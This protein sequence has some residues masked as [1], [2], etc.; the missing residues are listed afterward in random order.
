MAFLTWGELY[1]L[2][3]DPALEAW[4]QGVEAVAIHLRGLPE[5]RLVDLDAHIA[6]VAH[7]DGDSWRILGSSRALPTFAT[8][9]VVEA[10]FYLGQK[11]RAAATQAPTT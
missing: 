8:L 10:Y 7:R 11:A 9:D 3:P 1:E 4:L 5:L 2:R 6:H